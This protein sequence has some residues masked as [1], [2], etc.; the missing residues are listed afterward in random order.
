MARQFGATHAVDASESDPA[1]AV[2]DLTEGRGADVAFEVVGLEP[3]TM[4]GLTS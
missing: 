1:A 4:Q 3:S 2:R